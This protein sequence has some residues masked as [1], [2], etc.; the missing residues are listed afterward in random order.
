[1]ATFP[2]LIPSSRTFIPGEYPNTAYS[3]WSMVEGRVRH[4][5]VMLSSSIRLQFL[6]LSE[7]EMLSILN[8]YQG[9]LGGFTS[10]EIPSEVVSGFSVEDLQLS[11]YSWHYIEPPTVSDLPCGGHN[12]EVSFGSVP[13]EGAATPGLTKQLMM[14][15][16][17][18][19]A[20]ASGGITAS[21]RFRVSGGSPTVTADGIT[22][23]ATVSLDAG[24]AS[25]S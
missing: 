3:A 6:G 8:H 12:V 21:I 4:S 25:G 17:A 14:T 5:N 16:S 19:N 22:A 1:M 23:T 13:P 9:Q 20:A 7:S 2:A 18:G 15:L 10:F 11:G 24:A